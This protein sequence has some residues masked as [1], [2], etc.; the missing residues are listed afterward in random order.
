[1]SPALTDRTRTSD[2]VI[3]AYLSGK[4]AGIDAALRMLDEGQL[5]ATL[6]EAI[7]TDPMETPS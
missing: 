5:N 6:L 7:R 1:M 2:E 3:D 4:R